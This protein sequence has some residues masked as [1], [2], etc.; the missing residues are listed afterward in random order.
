MF[1]KDFS[2]FGL[3]FDT[4]QAYF[5]QYLRFVCGFSVKRR[6]L[7]CV[8]NKKSDNLNI[9]SFKSSLFNLFDII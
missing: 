5:L 6:I 8:C 1:A 9:L 4:F 7:R 2:W 3:H